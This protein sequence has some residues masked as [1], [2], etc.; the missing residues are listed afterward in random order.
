ML[1]ELLNGYC[2]YINQAEHN[3]TGLVLI[4]LFVL[5]LVVAAVL[6]IRIRRF[7]VVIV[8]AGIGVLLFLIA[9]LC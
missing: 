5:A 2:H 1:Q 8:P 3:P 9:L 4:G 7:R 6:C